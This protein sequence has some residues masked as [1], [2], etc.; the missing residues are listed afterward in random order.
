MLFTSFSSK[1]FVFRSSVPIFRSS[2]V[3]LGIL[4]Y[5]GSSDL[6]IFICLNYF[7]P[8]FSEGMS[9]IFLR[10]PFFKGVYFFS[11]IGQIAPQCF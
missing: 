6:T 4:Q 1:Y 10:P 3:E 7:I 8:V 9:H 2:R 5:T 11:G